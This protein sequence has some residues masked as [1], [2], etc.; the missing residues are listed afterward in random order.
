MKRL[1][2]LFCIIHSFAFSQLSEKTKE[3]LKP[4]YDYKYF[5]EPTQ[6][7]ELDSIKRNLIQNSTDEEF[8]YLAKEKNNVY[9]NAVAFQVLNEK[10]SA[11]FYDAFSDLLKTPNQKKIEF[12]CKIDSYSLPGYLIESIYTTT[13]YPNYKME[14]LF[15]IVFN[16]K[17][18]N[19]ELL[20][21]VYQLIP[22]K[23]EF[24]KL[25]K[26]AVENTR[27][28]KL[29]VALAKFQ[30][31]KDIK[32]IESFDSKA[33][34]AIEFFP[35][36]AFI[37]LFENS[38]YESDSTYYLFPLRN[39]CNKRTTALLEKFVNNE[40][41]NL[42]KDDCN[43]N[44]CLEGIYNL[45]NENKCE[46]NYPILYKMWR[47]N[48][49]ISY[50]V[51]DHFKLNHTKNETREFLLQGFLS[52]GELK[53]ITAIFP[54]DEYVPEEIRELEFSEEKQYIYLLNELRNYSE[55]DYQR[56]LYQSLL[57]I[58]T[59]FVD[60]F[61]YELQDNESVIKNSKGLF[62]K[63]KNNDNAYGLL[64]IMNGIKLLNNQ[65]LFNEGF[66]IIRQRR[67]E[68][69]EKAIWEKRLQEFIKENNLKL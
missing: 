37:Q 64:I 35:D 65:E 16:S 31:K 60:R 13:S 57:D 66:E 42:K 34:D 56:A 32:L 63:M 25:L 19:I 26:K 38:S 27:S 68:F 44:S 61:I 22:P 3:I 2:F 53:F 45:I 8:V 36:E 50:D 14:K 55:S 59:L 21:E 11:N 62:T 43:E 6:E 17:P 10:K 1:L 40:I 49:I 28:E 30:N 24:H 9:V 7:F 54:F 52:N 48:K 15:E 33:F 39:F 12:N 41:A 29:L 58:E 47:S 23:K 67:E 51:L 5:C 18:L 4:I 20:E 69:K 46:L